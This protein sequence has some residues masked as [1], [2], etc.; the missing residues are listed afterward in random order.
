MFGCSKNEFSKIK[1]GESMDKAIDVY[2]SAHIDLNAV[3]IFNDEE[4]FVIAIEENQDISGIVVFSSAGKLLHSEKITP[5]NDEN[6]KQFCGKSVEELEK[7]YG[8]FH[9]DTG[10]GF[11]IPAYITNHATIVFF[12]IENNIVDRISSTDILT[13]TTT[14]LCSTD[15]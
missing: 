5:I 14:E 2:K 12:E 4:N 10:S 7:Q 8:K 9:C 3:K 13:K 11:Y 6:I 15:S 1:I